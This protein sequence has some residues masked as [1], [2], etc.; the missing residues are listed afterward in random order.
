[1][2]NLWRF[3]SKYNALFLFIIF[4]VTSIILFIRNNDFQ[5]VSTLNTSN[6]VVGVFY[7][8]VNNVIKYIHLDTVNK[9]LVAENMLLRNQLK[10]SHFNDSVVVNTVTDT[11]NRVQYQYIAA[12]VI[13]KSVNS[14][15]NYITINRGSKHGIQKGMG[16][17]CP[18][19]VVGIVW[20]VSPDFATIQSVLHQDTKI[21]S[22]I[23]GTPYFGPLIWDGEN[24]QIA[25]LTDIPNQ[26]NLKKGTKISTSGLSV[27]F[28]KGIAVGTVLKAGVKGGGSFLNISVKL[29]TN[30]Y[31][32]QY[33]YVVKNIFATEQQDLENLNKT[34]GNE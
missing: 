14:R 7:S 9:E 4:F 3:I 30:F 21:T 32:L 12:E 34:Q 23:E 11:I 29:A 25:T 5:R 2:N 31:A 27:T 18:T 20:N 13:N 33:V 26:I 6:Q 1:M 24:S 10:A 22:S 8:K 15:N 28:P 19:G 17:I 16:V